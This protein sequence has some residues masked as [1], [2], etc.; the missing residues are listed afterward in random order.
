V[1]L[2]SPYEIV[3]P[4]RVQI[5]IFNISTSL[6]LGWMLYKR[7]SHL[8]FTYDERDFTLKRGKTDVISHKWSDF[9]KVSLARTEH[10]EFFLRLHGDSDFF[11][12]PVSKL[13]LDPF[14]FRDRAR[15]LVE[16]HR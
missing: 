15:K 12:I 6:T 4:L 8:T 14:L 13:K 10:G 7:K 11:E 5:L 1:V 3:A 2:L 16:S 9:S